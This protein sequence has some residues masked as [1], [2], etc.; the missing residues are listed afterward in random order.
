MGLNVNDR[1]VQSYLLFTPD[2]SPQKSP[3]HN[4][5]PDD[6]DSDATIIMDINIDNAEQ[7]VPTI[8]C[9]VKTKTFRIR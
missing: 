3:S 6:E 5:E 2:R 8:K 9:S 4:K 1:L 7:D